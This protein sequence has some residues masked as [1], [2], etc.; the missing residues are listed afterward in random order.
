[1]V[2]CQVKYRVCACMADAWV[3][4]VYVCQRVM[5]WWRYVSTCMLRYD[6][7]EIMMHKRCKN[8]LYH[9]KAKANHFIIIM[10]WPKSQGFIKKIRTVVTFWNLSMTLHDYEAWDI[11]SDHVRLLGGNWYKQR[12]KT[13]LQ[14]LYW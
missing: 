1:M 9:Y 4:T 3:C 14:S 11:V 10:Q 5:S 6:I 7:V 13:I 12:A 8:M 2:N